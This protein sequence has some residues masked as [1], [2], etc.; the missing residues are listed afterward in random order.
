MVLIP[1][2]DL[3]NGKCVRLLQGDYGKVTDYGYDPAQ[4]AERFQS[5]G[6]SR[7]H[8]VDLN[9]AK[10]DGDNR[11]TIAQIRESFSGVLE[12]GGGVRSTEDIEALLGIGVDRLIV[13]TILAKDPNLVQSWIA[14]YGNVFIAGIDA[15]DGM[16][17]VS[18]WEHD[19]GL[20]A[21]D[22]ARTAKEIGAVGIV[23]TSISRDGTLAG[24]DI[25]GTAE[26][27][28]AS[29]LPVI[30]SGGVGS[31]S[32]IEDIAAYGADGI[33]AVITGKAVYEGRID[34][35]KNLSTFGNAARAGW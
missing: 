1:S 23:Y 34:L 6:A 33:V 30:L 18:G 31:D 9:A 12:V 3:L 7:I 11:D 10:A 17:K 29:G 13:G 4:I 35:E 22:L 15:R 24:P 14:S 26:M 27:A 21:V 20:K 32:D 28:E 2:I 25:E 8:V 5:A 16:V 19:S